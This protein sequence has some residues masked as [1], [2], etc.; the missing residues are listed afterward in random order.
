MRLRSRFEVDCSFLAC[1]GAD[2]PKRLKFER[3]CL[4]CQPVKLRCQRWALSTPKDANSK[5]ENRRLSKSI[6]TSIPKLELELA[7]THQSSPHTHP[8]TQ[9]NDTPHNTHPTN[10]L[11]LHQPNPHT[12]DLPLHLP[13]SRVCRLLQFQH[14]FEFKSRHIDRLQFLRVHERK[15]FPNL[16]WD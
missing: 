16:L 3:S 2:R 15:C 1:I 8:N 12:P 6:R 4:S 14:P 13:R 9:K 7:R 5:I 10:L 11:L